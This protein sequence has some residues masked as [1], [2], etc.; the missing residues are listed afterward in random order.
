MLTTRDEAGPVLRELGAWAV[1]Q[2]YTEL[3]GSVRTALADE[4]ANLFAVTAGGHATTAQRALVDSWDP[5]PGPCTLVGSP[6]AGVATEAAVWLNTVAAV[7]TER[8]PGNRL[9][10]GHPALSVF[11]VLAL[12]ERLGSSGPDT[13]TALTVG[14]EVAARIGRATTCQ[15]DVH[16]HAV[17][18]APG[19][20]AGCAVLLGLD[21]DGVA[22]AIRAALAGIVA[23]SWTAA[24]AGSPVRDQ[25]AGAGAVAGLAAARLAATGTPLPGTWLPAV[26]GRL[27]TDGLVPECQDLLLGH[28]Y[29]KRH[30]ACA[31]THAAADAA[32]LVRA[33]LPG[34]GATPSDIRAVH[35]AATEAAVRLGSRSWTTRHGAYFSTPFAV[36]SALVHGDVGYQRSDPDQ[37][38]P[39]TRLI[40]L[41][42]LAGA[43]G[44]DARP[45]R[46]SVTLADGT[47]LAA[48]VPHSLG[49]ADHS[50]FDEATRRALLDDALASSGR[51][52]L[53]AEGV[54]GVVHALPTAAHA[55]DQIARLR[56]TG[57]DERNAQ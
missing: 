47:V 38:E 25:W 28:G 17:T 11:G 10:R 43:A 29:L 20:A 6:R 16:P 5:G 39:L 14:Y 50:P 21:A 48:A 56:P 52:P 35:V 9:A 41:E 40:E 32:L 45:A 2:R 37:A 49:D 1:A 7:C 3:S 36:A 27:D 46:V 13:L 26:I 19:T 53:T 55:A 34:V 44:S 15:A 33:Q 51:T 24:L 42:V 22:A 31:Y 57:D 54:L 23:S 8:D 30:S 18:G 12:A 4:L